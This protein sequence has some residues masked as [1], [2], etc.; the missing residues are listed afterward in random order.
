MIYR[1]KSTNSEIAFKLNIN[2]SAHNKKRKE[3]HD[4]D[5]NESING[6]KIDLFI[7]SRCQFATEKNST[8]SLSI[9]LLF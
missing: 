8:I 3:T 9:K 7:V 1:E 6:K 2:V 4:V 5:Y